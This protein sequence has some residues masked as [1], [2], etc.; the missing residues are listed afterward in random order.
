MAFDIHDTN[1]SKLSSHLRLNFSHLNEQNFRHNLNNT[2]DAMCT[3][4]LEPETIFHNILHGN[5]YST[6]RLE[7]LYNFCV[8]NPSLKNYSKEKLLNILLY[9]SEDFNCNDKEILKAKIKFLKI[10]KRFN[11]PFFDHSLKNFALMVLFFRIYFSFFL[12]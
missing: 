5:L 2:V 12:I 11:D 8:L 9:G 4:G 1:G 3:C 6:Q 10:S 7:L